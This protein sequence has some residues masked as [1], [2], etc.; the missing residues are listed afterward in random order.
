MATFSERLKELRKAK[1]V[2]LDDM[3][4][5]LN[6]TKSTLSRY[7][8]NKIEP[9]MFVLKKISDYFNVSLDFMAG[10][11]DEPR[12]ADIIKK[13][14]SDDP[15][16]ANFWDKLS[17]R[18]DLQLLFKQTKDMSPEGVKQI[19]RVIKAIENEEESRH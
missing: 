3:S 7:E 5:D 19:I 8:N 14:L 11:T 16:L 17:K 15:E 13:A 6:V 1:N 18:E 2:T 4:R 12:P 9:K 10:K